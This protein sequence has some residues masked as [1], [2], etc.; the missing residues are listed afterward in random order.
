MQ[1]SIQYVKMP[2]SETMTEYTIGK[3]QKLS[4]KYE[5]LI[6]AN[7]HFK[8]GQEATGVN[9]V[10]EIELSA[11]GPRIFATSKEKN[12]E[13]AV[14]ETIS[15]LERQLKKRKAVFTPHS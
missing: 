14:K 4:K 12:F 10:C 7:V 6:S 3:L 1:I 13:M 9:K 15:D 11:P 5:W 2:H 8:T